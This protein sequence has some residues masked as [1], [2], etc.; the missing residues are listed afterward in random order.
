VITVEMDVQTAAAVRQALY[1]EQEKYTYDP[2]CVPPRISNI[3]TVITDLDD[4]I[5]KE[6]DL[7]VEDETPNT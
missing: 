2:K 6:L 7:E 4:L 5:E 3:R 1:S